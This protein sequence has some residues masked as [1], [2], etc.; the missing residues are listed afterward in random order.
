MSVCIHF[1]LISRVHSQPRFRFLEAYGVN[2]NYA[3]RSDIADNRELTRPAGSISNVA[4][5]YGFLLRAYPAPLP[6]TPPKMCVKFEIL[7]LTAMP[8]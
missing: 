2:S 5:V 3:H 6:T 4:T 8:L 7:S 1:V